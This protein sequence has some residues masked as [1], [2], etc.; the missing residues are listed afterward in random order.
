S[1]GTDPL[2]ADTDDDGLL[3][4]YEVSIGTD[5]LDADT[6][7]DGLLDGYEVSIGTDPLDADTDDDGLLDG[8][9]DSCGT[10]PLDSDTDDDG[11]LDGE[12]VE[13]IQNV[14]NML[15]DDAFMGIAKSKG[16]CSQ[17]HRTVILKILDAVEEYLLTGE[18][19]EAIQLLT[20]LRKHVDGDSNADNNDWILADMAR[21]QVRDLIDVLLNNLAS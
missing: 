17:D 11:L 5:P 19:E 6:D 10:D 20:N 18:T 2:D 13:F 12:D 4:G 1:I 7:D 14:V 3:D 21:R 8:I 15:P 16:K 9:E